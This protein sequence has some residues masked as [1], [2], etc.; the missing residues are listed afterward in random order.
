MQ[1]RT[2]SANPNKA[3]AQPAFPGATQHSGSASPA[4]LRGWQL[5]SPAQHPPHARCPTDWP[6]PMQRERTVEGKREKHQFGL[7]NGYK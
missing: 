3:V 5:C 7:C 4:P 2:T 6:K 1:C